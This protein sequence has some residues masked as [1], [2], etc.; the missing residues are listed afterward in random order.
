MASSYKKTS[1]FSRPTLGGA[2]SYPLLCYSVEVDMVWAVTNS[3]KNPSRW[4]AFSF[5][6]AVLYFTCCFLTALGHQNL[7][8][9]DSWTDEEGAKKYGLGVFI[10]NFQVL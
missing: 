4:K 5:M 3:T 10:L 2:G 6:H 9:S 1:L 7:I 8:H